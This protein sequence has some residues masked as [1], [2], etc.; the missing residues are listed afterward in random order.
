MKIFPCRV[1]HKRLIFSIS[2]W[3]WDSE[4]EQGLWTELPLT[5][6]LEGTQDRPCRLPAMKQ[7]MTPHPLPQGCQGTMQY[8]SWV[9]VG[10]V[11]MPTLWTSRTDALHVGFCWPWEDPPSGNWRA[12]MNSAA[13]HL[14]GLHMPLSTLARKAST[15]LPQPSRLQE[16]LALFQPWFC[17]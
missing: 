14:P 15:D 4:T 6:P 2:I 12:Q 9:E 11:F 17:G 10:N 5:L 1:P 3:Q 7:G 16:I 8:L 13:P